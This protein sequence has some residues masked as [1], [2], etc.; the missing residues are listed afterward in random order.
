MMESLV[1]PLLRDK[2]ACY[3]IKASRYNET[4]NQTFANRFFCNFDDLQHEI[5]I[6]HV[7]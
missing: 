5:N 6:S 1:F 4:L 3:E 7:S 2:F